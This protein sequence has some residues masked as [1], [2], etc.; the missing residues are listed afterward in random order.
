[1]DRR[2]F[3]Q[4]LGVGAAALGGAVPSLRAAGNSRPNVVLIVCDDLNDYVAG[5]G[6]HPQTRTPNLARLSEQGVCFDRAYS[7]NPICAPSRSSF[8]TGIYPHTSH[9]HM[10]AKW[11]E[12][13]VLQNCHT[14]MEYFKLN[15]YFVT[16]S[17][18]LMHHGRPQEWSEFKYPAD[19][20]PFWYRDGERVAHPSVPEPYRTIG[21]VDG[22]F[23]ALEDVPPKDQRAED[24]GWVYGSWGKVERL[25][26]RSAED[27]DPTPDERNAAWA[28]GTIQQLDQAGGDEPFFLGV[29]FIRPHT[30]LHVPQKYFD[31]F[32][33]EDVEL[34]ILKE[35]DKD[36]TG[37][38]EVAGPNAKGPLYFRMLKETYGGTLEGLRTFTR[39]YL[40]SVAAVD[41]CV[42]QVLNALDGSRFADNTIVVVTGDHGWNMGQKDWLF[43]MSLWEESCRVPL[44]I[45]APGV[46]KAGQRAGQPVS[47][48]DLYP[49]LADLCGLEGDTRKN[50]M[51]KPLDGHSL[52][53]FLADPEHGIWDGPDAALSMVYSGAEYERISEMQHFSV[54]SRDFRY[55]RYNGGF[56]ELY[57][58]R[59][60]PYEW[61]NL[62]GQD[63]YQATRK[64]LRQ[65]LDDMTGL[66]IGVLPPPEPTGLDREGQV[67]MDLESFDVAA[68]V[69]AWPPPMKASITNDAT[70]VIDGQAS[71][72]LTS[73]GKPWNIGTFNS[74]A[75][76]PGMTCEIRFDARCDAVV[77]DG[78]LYFILTRGQIKSQ[79]IKVPLKVGEQ[80]TATGTLTNDQAITL[81]LVIGFSKGG[82]YLIDNLSVR[83]V[84][85][86]P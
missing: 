53:P 32:P 25:E 28:A 81:N 63:A 9:N 80:T 78:F 3:L 72:L 59:N 73:A 31:Q 50:A 16:G 34:P 86:N 54:R 85:R 76:P 57:D 10:F 35:G 27:R 65:K 42:G 24:E 48:V 62:V 58:H 39:A 55:V 60:D 64:E 20:G 82:S 44:I 30:P 12:N 14:L 47:L 33:L 21:P 71:L 46:A 69:N 18:K 40:A 74:I 56:E 66:K 45:R 5:F 52:R 67:S 43:K 79:L 4:H 8:L 70:K 77:E 6:G 36:D 38:E 29:G 84:D 1:M 19:Y 13:P 26:I 61:T 49:T 37:L 83:R 7:N 17:G 11:F 41:D 22:S 51:G 23:G 2:S 68:E 15:G 75:V